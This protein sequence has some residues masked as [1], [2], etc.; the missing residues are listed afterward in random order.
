MGR[1]RR[2]QMPTE[3]VEARIE[4]L[5]HDG[6]G[7]ARVDGKAVFVDNALPGEQVMFRYTWTRKRFDEARAETVLEAAD[8]R[9]E[10][11]CPHTDICGGCSLQHLDPDAQ[12][13]RKE[14]VLA[15]QLDHFGGLE[16]AEW[17]APL[18]GPETG[19]RGQ[20]RLGVKYLEDRGALVGFREK[21]NSKVADIRQCE[22]L[23]PELGHS[24]EELRALIERLATCRRIPQIEVSAGD[25]ALALIFRHLDPLPDAD[26]R[27]LVAFC[28]ARGWHCYLQPGNEDTA[29]RIWPEEG[30]ERLHLRHPD[31]GLELAFHPVDFMQVNLDMNR[32]MVPRAVELLDLAPQHRVLD[33][34]CGLGNFSLP[35]ATRAGEVVGVEGSRAMVERGYENARRNHRDNVE[36]HSW[37]LTRDPAHQSWAKQ[38]FDRV[39]LDPPRSG[40]AEMI[41]HLPKLGPDRIVYVSCNPATLA[42]DAGALTRHGYTLESAGIMD[43]FPHTN[44]TESI[45]VFQQR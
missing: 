31:S 43:M 28:R 10:P 40:A 38:G 18:T 30:P 14:A 3:P 39:L 15:E 20:A 33:L 32:R 8:E 21:R 44:H 27:E 12:R 25:D 23:L 35:I 17:L 34:F 26:Q 29:H 42:R 22:V 24:L 5:S 6:R 2:K 37:D 11:V 36:F 45:A 19:Y 1:R 4:G 16:P 9:V 13:R 41:E 7:V